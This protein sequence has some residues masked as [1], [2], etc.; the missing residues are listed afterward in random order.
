[1]EGHKL[2]ISSQHSA[3]T[4]MKLVRLRDISLASNWGGYFLLALLTG[5]NLEAVTSYMTYVMFR[6]IQTVDSSRHVHQLLILEIF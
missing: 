2:C 5:Q 6:D 4:F 1:M 3:G